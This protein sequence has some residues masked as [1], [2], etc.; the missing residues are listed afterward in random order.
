MDPAGRVYK[1]SVIKAR[2]T[3]DYNALAPRPRPR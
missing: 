3:G 2:M 1:K